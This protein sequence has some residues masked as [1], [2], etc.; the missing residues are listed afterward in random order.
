MT[1]AVVLAWSG[2]KDSLL[3]LHALAQSPDYTVTTLM[4]GADPTEGRVNMHGVRLELIAAQAEALGLA[5]HVVDQPE[6]APN[7]VYEQNMREAYLQHRKQGVRYIAHGD[8]AL[9]DLRDY[10]ERL[11]RYVGLRGLYPLWG[12][13]TPGLVQELLALGYR[14]RV[15]CVDTQQLDM[16]FAGR[17]LD[18]E[19]LRDLPPGVDPCGENGEYHS[20][21]YEGPLFRRPIS[22]R[23]GDYW[24]AQGRFY[25]CDLLPG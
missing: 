9:A 1:Q 7:E 23:A 6:S 5:L 16:S 17:E 3:S 2:G 18:A 22:I 14:A 13:D 21:V 19:F 11:L 8:V 15:V 24:L 4:T 25:H 12:R 10:R 20:F